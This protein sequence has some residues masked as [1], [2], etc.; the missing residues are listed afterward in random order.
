MDSLI[1]ESPKCDSHKIYEQD[2]VRMF[3]QTNQGWSDQCET[4]SCQFENQNCG[5]QQRYRHSIERCRFNEY[6]YE[7]ETPFP[8]SYDV[9][10]VEA[11]NENSSPPN[12]PGSNDSLSFTSPYEQYMEMNYDC[13]TSTSEY[14]NKETS[15][16]QIPISAN[17]DHFDPKLAALQKLVE[18][19]SSKK[20]WS[21]AQQENLPHST[22][23]VKKI[24]SPKVSF[25]EEREDKPS[26]KNT[27][28]EINLSP[29]KQKETTKLTQPTLD[30]TKQSNTPK[31][32]NQLNAQKIKTPQKIPDSK[33]Q[34]IMKKSEVTKSKRHRTRFAPSQLSELE[35]SFSSTHYPDIFMREEIAHRI[36]LTESRVQVWFQNRR[37]K[38]KKRKAATSCGN[39]WP[40]QTAPAGNSFPFSG[41]VYQNS[42]SSAMAAA[43][44]NESF[45]AL[46]NSAE[47]NWVTN[48]MTGFGK[49]I[50]YGSNCMGPTTF[51][52][53][54]M[55]MTSRVSDDVIAP[56]HPHED[57][58]QTFPEYPPTNV[59]YP[60]KSFYPPDDVS[61]EFTEKRV[62]NSPSQT[63]VTQRSFPMQSNPMPLYG[64]HY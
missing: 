51:P 28:N 36:G 30:Q 58:Y 60:H 53:Q 14:E 61:G 7:R 48:A 63:H 9:S 16:E 8:W 5:K 52:G 11:T 56:N 38:W 20:T 24:E 39:P 54:V 13:D 32:T 55:D 25:K 23:S 27:S 6:G 33:K 29:P 47:G 59:N 12:A 22:I 4:T 31:Q 64:A 10:G 42:P 44:A 41:Q 45:Y 18:N 1:F 40:F 19:Q 46:Q 49:D 15:A 21:C 57:M 62:S 35:R 26:T 2:T 17:F 50:N 37:A 34:E 3:D 43:F